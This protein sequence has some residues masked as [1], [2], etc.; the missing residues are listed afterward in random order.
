MVKISS[1]DSDDGK[2]KQNDRTETKVLEPSL[3]REKTDL[4]VLMIATNRI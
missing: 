4:N 3:Q 1:C 2:V